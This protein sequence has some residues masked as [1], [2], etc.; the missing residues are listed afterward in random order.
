V[1]L[2]SGEVVLCGDSCYL[3]RSLEELHLP[4]IAH[5]RDAMIE[6]LNRLRALRDGGARIFYG[7]D[8]EFWKEVP[9]LQAL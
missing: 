7:H 3:R 8:P 5:D 4:G 6:S 1:K 2:E 9:Q